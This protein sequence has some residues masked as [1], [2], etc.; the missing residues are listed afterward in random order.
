[1]KRT[2][3]HLEPP[4]TS[5]SQISTPILIIISLLTIILAHQTLAF[6]QYDIFI[7]ATCSQAKSQPNSLFQTNLK[8]LLSSLYSSSSHSPYNTSTTTTTDAGPLYGLYQCRGDLNLVDCSRCIESAVDQLDLECPN[9][10]EASLQLEGCFLRYGQVDFFGKRD[11]SVRFQKCSARHVDNGADF[12][13]SRDDVL[14]EL[15]ATVGAVGFKVTTS[16]SVEGYA[17]CSGDLMGSGD[18]SCVDC[19][20]EA[21]DKLKQLCGPTAA[22]A[23]VYLG[24]CYARYWASGYYDFTP[25]ESRSKNDE[26]GKTVTIIVG[27]IAGLALLVVVLS[28]CIKSTGGRRT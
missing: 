23:E 1:M 24:K 13:R 25:T 9:C 6:P 28:I 20:T 14:E 26:M 27:V 2:L 19:V 21:V 10:L 11:T 16:R 17:Q 5:A 12:V 7:Y 18:D 15:E 8:S 22:A 3:Q 4:S